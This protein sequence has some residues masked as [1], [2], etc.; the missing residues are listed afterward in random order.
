MSPVSATYFG[1][2]GYVIFW[3]MF[4]ITMGLFVPRMF[5]LYKLMLLGKPE[6]R[7]DRIG[8]RIKNTLVTV[9]PQWCTLKSVTAKDLA[10]IGH[11]V[12]FWGFSFFLLSYI[13]L[14]GLG[15][16]LGLH[17]FIWGNCLR[18][19]LPFNSRHSGDPG[20]GG[21]GMGCNQALYH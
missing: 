21:N 20:H 2:S 7:F 5:F 1:I 9:I 13:I 12:M 4:A 15:E 10:G 3:V 17:T 8:E 11:A 19:S 16:G 18:D 14:I 6:N